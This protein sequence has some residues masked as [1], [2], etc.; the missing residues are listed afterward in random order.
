MAVVVVT[1]VVVAALVVVIIPVVVAL[2]AALVVVLMAL[3]VTL[4]VAALV[5][6]VVLV[7]VWLVPLVVDRLTV[8]L[9]AVVRAL[10]RWPGHA[11][12]E[13]LAAHHVAALRWNKIRGSCWSRWLE[14]LTG[15]LELEIGVRDLHSAAGKWV[16]WS[17]CLGWLRLGYWGRLCHRSRLGWLLNGLHWCS[18]LLSRRWH[19][20][21]LRLRH[22]R[23]LSSKFWL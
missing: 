12:F 20:R 9:W 14:R 22:G 16:C 13:G 21:L 5:V 4:V 11:R 10:I 23:L 7:H 6:I 8:W 19:S 3:V 15:W 1:I 2:V 17:C 18:S